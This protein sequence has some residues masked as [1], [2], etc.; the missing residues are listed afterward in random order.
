[1]SSHQVHSPDAD[2]IDGFTENDHNDSE[3]S[4]KCQRI[5]KLD[6]SLKDP[7]TLTIYVEVYPHDVLFPKTTGK[8][9]LSQPVTY[10]NRLPFNIKL[11]DNY[12]I[13]EMQLVLTLSTKCQLLPRD[14]LYWCP[15]G[16][17]R[18]HN[19]ALG[20]EVGY[21]AMLQSFTKGLSKGRLVVLSMLPPEKDTNA[22]DWVTGDDYED[23]FKFDFTPFNKGNTLSTS[24]AE[25]CQLFDAAHA[26]YV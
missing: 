3:P 13:F 1:M 7:L 12:K 25:Q 2:A 17:P 14:K 16:K 10:I 26:P 20:G 5:S 23:K 11:T 4:P 6:H 22:V 9:A 21:Q 18:T 15:Q 19:C 8:K 24:A